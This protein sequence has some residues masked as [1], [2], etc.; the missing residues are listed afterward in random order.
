MF[1]E[2]AATWD[3][4]PHVAQLASDAAARIKEA[5]DLTGKVR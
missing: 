2:Q 3:V 5:T 1:D 4:K